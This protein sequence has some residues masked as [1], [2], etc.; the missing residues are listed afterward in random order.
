MPERA[1][2][3]YIAMEDDFSPTT[4]LDFMLAMHPEAE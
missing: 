4:V 2:D 1:R 3:A